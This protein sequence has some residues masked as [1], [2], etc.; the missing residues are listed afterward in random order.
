MV[1]RALMSRIFIQRGSYSVEVN[2]TAFNKNLTNLRKI[3]KNS[4]IK[5]CIR[6]QEKP[7][8]TH[9]LTHTQ[10][11]TRTHIHTHIHT[12]L[13]THTPQ[14]EMIAGTGR[15]PVLKGKAWYGRPP[16]TNHRDGTN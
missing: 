1:D 3:V 7:P 9:T 4:D 14:T 12:H 5:C 2:L 8:H 16:C 11:H 10:T 6:Y 13:H 15:E